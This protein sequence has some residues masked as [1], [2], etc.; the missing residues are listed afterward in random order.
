MKPLRLADPPAGRKLASAIR[1]EWSRGAAPDAR[2][3]LARHPR[4]LEDESVVLDLAYEEYCRRRQAGEEVDRE[5]FCA[6]FP[7]VRSRLRNMLDA[8]QLLGGDSDFLQGVFN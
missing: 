4:L 1:A 6:N 7:G 8:E 5:G 3:A 2:A